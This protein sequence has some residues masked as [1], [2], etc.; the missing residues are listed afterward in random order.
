MNTAVSTSQHHSPVAELFVS[1]FENT[2][3]TSTESHQDQLGTAALPRNTCPLS[4][5]SPQLEPRAPGRDQSPEQ[6]QHRLGKG[7]EIVVPVDLVVVSHGNFPKHL[8]GEIIRGGKRIDFVIL[9]EETRN[10]PCLNLEPTQ[11][12]ATPTELSHTPDSSRIHKDVPGT[13]L[14]TGTGGGRY[15]LP[16]RS[17]DPEGETGKQAPGS[18]PGM[19]AGGPA[20]QEA[21]GGPHS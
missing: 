8:G 10:S 18:S 17:S 13:V 21:Q 9:K 4:L 20:A 15:I 6:Q 5:C 3:Q 7:L 16:S 12:R 2:K 1:L 19:R 14:T 11:I